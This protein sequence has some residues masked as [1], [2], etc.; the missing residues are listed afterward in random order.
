[1]AG[2]PPAVGEKPVTTGMPNAGNR[3]P[4]GHERSYP[5]NNLRPRPRKVERTNKTRPGN[6]PSY[7]APYHPPTMN[8]VSKLSTYRYNPSFPQPTNLRKPFIKTNKTLK[9]ALK[10]PHPS[11]RKPPSL[12]ESTIWNSLTTRKAKETTQIVQSVF[13]VGRYN[14]NKEYTTVRTLKVTH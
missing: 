7:L 3:K 6:P 14:T 1:M 9:Q 4:L 11:P 2:I 10:E 13:T 12:K 8:S 5:P